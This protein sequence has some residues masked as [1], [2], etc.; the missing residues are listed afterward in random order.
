VAGAGKE[1]KV[2]CFL[3][4]SVLRPRHFCIG[5]MVGL[6]LLQFVLRF[7]DSAYTLLTSISTLTSF[8]TLSSLSR[9]VLYTLYTDLQLARVGLSE[10]AARE[11]GIHYRLTKLPMA[12]LPFVLGRWVPHKVP[13]KRS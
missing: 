5:I 9:Q 11:A 8:Q 7:S 3:R 6:E 4:V 10:S 12:A 13:R 2:W 1:T